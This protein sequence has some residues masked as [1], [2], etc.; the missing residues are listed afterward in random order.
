MRKETRRQVT[1]LAVVNGG[2]RPAR[3]RKSTTSGS[4]A[5]LDFKRTTASIISNPFYR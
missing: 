3:Q 2:V 1:A 5:L 4:L